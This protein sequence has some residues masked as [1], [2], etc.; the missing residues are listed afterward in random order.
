MRI[1]SIADLNGEEYL[2]EYQ[3]NMYL[4]DELISATLNLIRSTINAN[5]D[6]LNVIMKMEQTHKDMVIGEITK[7]KEEKLFDDINNQFR[8]KY[9]LWLHEMP[10]C[11]LFYNIINGSEVL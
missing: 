11:I 1:Y 7:E 8:N 10:E 3:P 9:K 6:V 4:S 5:E 2:P